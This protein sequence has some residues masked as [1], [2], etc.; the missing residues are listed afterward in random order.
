M[1]NYDAKELLM[2]RDGLSEREAQEELNNTR[3][4]MLLANSPFEA[5]DMIMDDLALEEDY[6]WSIF[7]L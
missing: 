1:T 2:E 7:G 4:A 6:L 3:N 5:L